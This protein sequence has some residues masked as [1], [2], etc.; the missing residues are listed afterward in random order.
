MLSLGAHTWKVTAERYGARADVEDQIATAVTP[1]RMKVQSET[2]HH[3]SMTW[4]V[5]RCRQ[6]MEDAIRRGWISQNLTTHDDRLSE[7]HRCPPP[8]ARF[9]RTGKNDNIRR[10]NWTHH[11]STNGSNFES[12]H[13]IEHDDDWGAPG[14]ESWDWATT[15]AYCMLGDNTVVFYKNV[16]ALTG[17]CFWLPGLVLPP[18]F[19]N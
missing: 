15:A 7:E 5:S 13:S 11:E 17:K 14:Q 18:F 9:S 2:L 19:K 4:W 12:P 8:G 10:V 6:G 3:R 16:T 1:Q